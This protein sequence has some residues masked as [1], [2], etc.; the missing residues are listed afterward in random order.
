MFYLWIM[1][2]CVLLI[3]MSGSVI[4]NTKWHTWLSQIRFSTNQDAID[5]H[6]DSMYLWWMFKT[7]CEMKIVFLMNIFGFLW[8]LMKHSPR[9]IDRKDNFSSVYATQKL[10]LCVSLWLAH[11]KLKIYNLTWRYKMCKEIRHIY[12]YKHD[13][14]PFLV[15]YIWDFE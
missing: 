8:N 5:I 15:L 1:I 2:T 7:L 14:A 6:V 11:L 4:Y 12:C 9:S 13:L 10:P 3:N